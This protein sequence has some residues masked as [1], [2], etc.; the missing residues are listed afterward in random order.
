MDELP[1]RP[2]AGDST[3]KLENAQHSDGGKEDPNK[4]KINVRKR[5]KTGCMS[6]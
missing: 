2:E 5:T 6:K 4:R 1:T 3:L